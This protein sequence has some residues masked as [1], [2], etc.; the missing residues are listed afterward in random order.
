MIKKSYSITPRQLPPRLAR[1]LLVV[2][3]VNGGISCIAPSTRNTSFQI[4]FKRPT[5]AIAFETAA[6]PSRFDHFWPG[7]KPCHEKSSKRG[8]LLPFWLLNVLRATMPCTFP[9]SQRPKVVRDS[10]LL[11]LCSLHNCGTFWRSQRPKVLRE[12]CA[13]NIFTWECAWR[14]GSL[15][16]LNISTSKTTP[17]LKCFVHVDLEMCFAPQW[18]ALLPHLSVKLNDRITPQVNFVQKWAT[19]VVAGTGKEGKTKEVVED[20]EVRQVVCEELCLAKCHAKRRWMS[21]SATPAT[22]NAPARPS[23]PPE[24]AQCPKCHA[25]HAKRRWTSLD[26]TKCPRLPRKVARRPGRRSAPKRATRASPVLQVPRLPRETEV[27]VTKPHLP[28]EMKVD[29]TK[30]HACHAKLCV[31]D[32]VWQSWVWK[33]VCDKVCVWKMVCDKVVCERGSVKDVVWQSCLWKMVC[34]KVVCEKRCDKVVCE[35]WCVKKLC[36]KIVTKCHEGGRHQVMPATRNQGG[37]HQNEGGCYQVPHLPRETKVD[38][39]KCH[40]CHA[41]WRGAT[42]DPARPSAPPEPAQCPK[43]HACNTKRRWMSPSAMP[44]RQAVHRA[45]QRPSAPPEPA[46]C[47]KCHACFHTQRCHTFFRTQLCHTPSLIHNFAW[48]AWRLVTSTF[49]S[50][51]RRRT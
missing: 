31:K 32:G 41:K 47:S 7:S 42:G 6:K 30:C 46:Q 18:R 20:R 27:D 13:F 15:H 25:C 17:T 48:Q 44:S 3:V 49:V 9:T 24:P 39:T 10:R 1:V 36:V 34:N 19:N 12:W 40:A 21:P 45:T 28:R 50:R 43:C 33:M 14:H 8:V 29:V 35:S 4:L 37:C 51:G 26:V 16:F 22:Q 23:A 2:V 5:P 11:P 38:V